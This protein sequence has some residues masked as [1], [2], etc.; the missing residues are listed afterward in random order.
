ML[1]RKIQ[2]NPFLVIEKATLIYKNLQDYL[3]DPYQLHGRHSITRRIEKWIRWIPHI[4][5]R[6]KLNFNGSKI[7]N[8]SVLGW[9]IR[10]SNGIIKMVACRH[11]GNSSII[12][13]ECMVLRDCNYVPRIMV[14]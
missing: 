14:F 10:D 7:H 4:N 6:F 1:F 8:T 5:G 3:I 11:I 9:V 13:V 2:P 12:V